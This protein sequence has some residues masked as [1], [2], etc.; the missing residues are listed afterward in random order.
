MQWVATKYQTT[1]KCSY[2]YT[3]T[4]SFLNINGSWNI[5]QILLQNFS[6]LS[7]RIFLSF[8]TS[9]ANTLLILRSSQDM[10]GF[11]VCDFCLCSS[12][13]WYRD[14]VVMRMECNAFWTFLEKKKSTLFMYS[15]KILQIKKFTSDYLMQKLLIPC[16]G[17]TEKIPWNLKLYKQCNRFLSSLYGLQVFSSWIVFVHKCDWI[18]WN[19]KNKNKNRVLRSQGTKT[20]QHLSQGILNIEQF[21][22]EH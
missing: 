16:Y 5:H 9:S 20:S 15:C 1:A 21:K 11:C 8:F 7:L 2:K 4:I 18:S 12:L 22:A 14:T 3:L 19:K 17:G 6:I 13:T 10:A